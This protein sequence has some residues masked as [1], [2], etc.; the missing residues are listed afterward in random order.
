MKKNNFKKTLLAVTLAASIAL[1]TASVAGAAI[2]A[3]AAPNVPFCADTDGNGAYN[4][5]ENL[6]YVSRSWY[7]A[8]ARSFAVTTDN[9]SRGKYPTSQ[10]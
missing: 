10:G 2:A 9:L 5:R 8:S 7:E 4:I 6:I 3:N 1:P